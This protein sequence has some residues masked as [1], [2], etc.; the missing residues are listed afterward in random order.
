MKTSKYSTTKTWVF[1]LAPLVCG[2][3]NALAFQSALFAAGAVGVVY[4]PM[5]A[6][7]QQVQQDPSY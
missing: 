7:A 1:R 2:V 4:F 3:K 5:T 6:V